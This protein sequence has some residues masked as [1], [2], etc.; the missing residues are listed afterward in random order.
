MAKYGLYQREKGDR[1]WERVAPQLWWSS[2]QEAAR[3][4]QDWLLNGAMRGKERAVR[5][6][7]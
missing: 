5:Q 7:K 2:T 4:G 6:I 1:Y 3:A